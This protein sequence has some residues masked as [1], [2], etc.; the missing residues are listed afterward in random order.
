[1]GPS[2]EQQLENTVL[3]KP[4]YLQFPE[5]ITNFDTNGAFYGGF[6][7]RTQILILTKVS[8][9]YGSFKTQ[10]KFQ[11]LALSLFYLFT[12]GRIIFPI[13]V[14]ISLPHCPVVVG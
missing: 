7:C 14:Y 12:E 13:V 9:L 5:Q 11:F 6:H 8:K 2:L 4:G 10:P 3:D 1:M